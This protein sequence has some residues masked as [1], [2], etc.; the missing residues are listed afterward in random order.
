[1]IVILSSLKN[2]VFPNWVR[3]VDLLDAANDGTSLQSRKTNS[4]SGPSSS[5]HS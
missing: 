1:M 4:G 3:S 2:Y 5:I